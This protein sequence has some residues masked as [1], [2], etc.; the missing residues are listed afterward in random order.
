VLQHLRTEHQVERPI[1]KWQ[2]PNI[3]ERELV[4]H[5]FLDVAREIYA[6]DVKLFSEQPGEPQIQEADF[7]TRWC[8][9]RDRAQGTRNPIHFSGREFVIHLFIGY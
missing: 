5:I 7:Q 9:G 1:A 4:R 2:L 3:R 8:V 6:D